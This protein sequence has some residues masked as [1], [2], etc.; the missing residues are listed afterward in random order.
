MATTPPVRPFRA[1]QRFD[2]TVPDKTCDEAGR[3]IIAWSRLEA[4]LDDLVWHFLDLSDNDGRQVTARLDARSKGQMLRPLGARYLA[5]AE[6]AYF[7][8][9]LNRVGDLQ[10]N[11]NFIAHGI[12]GTIQPENVAIAMSLRPEATLGEIMSETF[13]SPRMEDILADIGRVIHE[14][15][16]FRDALASLRQRSVKPLLPSGSIPLPSR[17]APSPTRR[18]RQRRSSPP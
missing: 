10:A 3:I 2:P 4:G 6:A 1:D 11:R 8:E 14:L 12:W 15:V 18:R 16:K 13:P 5:S 9:L 7:N 17:Q